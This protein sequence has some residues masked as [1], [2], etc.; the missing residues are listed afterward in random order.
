MKTLL[1]DRITYL[2]NESEDNYDKIRRFID[3]F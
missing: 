2:I 1:I 3:E